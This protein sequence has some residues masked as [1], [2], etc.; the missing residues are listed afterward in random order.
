MHFSF[1]QILLLKKNALEENLIIMCEHFFPNKL[2][3]VVG[4]TML[5]GIVNA[6]LNLFYALLFTVLTLRASSMQE[7]ENIL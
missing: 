7:K 1:L 6:S 4:S 5:M 3:K 2:L